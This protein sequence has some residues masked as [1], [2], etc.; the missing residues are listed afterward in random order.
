MTSCA[1]IKRAHPRWRGEDLTARDRHTPL[2]GSSP[3]ARGGPDGVGTVL[4]VV[5]LIPAGA[6][7]TVPWAMSGTGGPAH[8]RWRGE[9]PRWSSTRV[10]V[11]GSSPLARGG[12]VMVVLLCGL[13]GLIPAGAGRTTSAGA[14]PVATGAHPR[15]RGEDRHSPGR[16]E[17]GLGSSPLARGGRRPR[18]WG[19]PSGGAHPRWRGEDARAA[20]RTAHVSG[21]SPLARGGQARLAVVFRRAGLIPAGAGRTSR[22]L[23]GVGMVTAH[24]RWRGE[25][26]SRRPASGGRWG[27]SPLARGGRDVV[28]SPTQPPRLIPA[29][30]GRTLLSLRAM[31]WWRAHPRW[32]GEDPTSGGTPPPRPGS[33]PLARGGLPRR[34]RPM[35]T[36][37]LI[38]AGAGRTSTGP[39]CR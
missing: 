28:Y 15:W 13:V 14:T 35:T 8:P 10:A 34:R 3:L 2:T 7:R 6:G 5:G 12:L 24:P 20:Q 33:S 25:D 26:G 23:L 4:L 36:D 16:I 18:P 37:R 30:A 39:R 29:G 1:R 9:D 27:S 32:R 17:Y 38:P 19:A 31:M 22:F 11:A 21:S